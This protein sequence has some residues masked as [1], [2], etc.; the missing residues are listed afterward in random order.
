MDI[1]VNSLHT[2]VHV[3]AGLTFHSQR[4]L[5]HLKI[6]PILIDARHVRHQSDPLGVLKNIGRRAQHRFGF[7]PLELAGFV[8]CHLLPLCCCL[9]HGRISYEACNLRCVVFIDIGRNLRGPSQG[10][11]YFTSI[12]RGRAASRRCIW[13]CRIPSR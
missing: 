9:S 1:R 8:S 3:N 11:I 7:A 10:S 2:L 6:Q 5:I 13:I 4:I 12:C